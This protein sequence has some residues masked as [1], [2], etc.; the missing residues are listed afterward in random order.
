M[1]DNVIIEKKI[2]KMQ[3]QFHEIITTNYKWDQHAQLNIMW[4]RDHCFI[5]IDYCEDYNRFIYNTSKKEQISFSFST[6]L[7]TIGFG[8]TWRAKYDESN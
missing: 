5:D 1:Q 8:N 3:Q 6:Y 4:K 7:I 2:E